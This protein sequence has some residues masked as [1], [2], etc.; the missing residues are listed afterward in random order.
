MLCYDCNSTTLYQNRTTFACV[1]KTVCVPGEQYEDITTLD[2]GRGDRVCRNITKFQLELKGPAPV[3]CVQGG[4]QKLEC[5]GVLV[6]YILK[7]A[8]PTADREFWDWRPCPTG[9]YVFQHLV[10][11]MGQIIKQQ[12]CK[13][14]TPQPP[15]T[16]MIID[17]T[18]SEDRDNVY[19]QLTVCG[20]GEYQVSPAYT[21]TAAVGKD[22]SC[23]PYRKC[24]PATQYVLMGGNETSDRVCATR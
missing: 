8:T 11:S 24:D 12:I 21:P 19:A 1:N 17:G 15:G 20:L 23:A 3:W 10:H 6:K 9:E 18:D 22:R 16:Y 14:Y 2:A 7:P 4:Y 13:P 5:T